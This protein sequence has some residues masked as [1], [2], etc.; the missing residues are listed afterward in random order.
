MSK[1]VV[2]GLFVHPIKSAAAIAVDELTLDDRGAV[3]DRRWLVIDADGLA[4][5][6]RTTPR[7]A[8]VRQRFAGAAATPGDGT[9][10]NADG[11]LQLDALGHSPLIVP[12][13]H[14]GAGRRVTIWDDS[15]SALD[16][17]DE[18]A[19]WL[20]SA[21]GRSCRLVRIDE[22]AARP[23]QAKYA[24]PLSNTGRRVA[25]SDGA[26]LLLLGQASVDALSERLVEQ[27]GEAMSVAR[28]RPNVLLTTTRPHE[29]DTWWTIRVG[30]V[31]LGVGSACSRCVMITIDPLSGEKGIEPT[32][33]LA[34][35]RRQDGDVVF[36]MNA[37]HARPGVLRVGDAVSVHAL[38]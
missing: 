12:V 24:G 4:I 5:T 27:G 9:R 23:L 13:P 36:G 7:L 10:R 11:A 25:F 37:T 17:G 20:S 15:L 18:A 31:E 38:R 16:A 8:L 28:F 19:A 14:G 33:T 32:R 29:E 34:T 1:V 22:A 30:D 26:P 2:A 21:I 35:Y 6:A 3:G